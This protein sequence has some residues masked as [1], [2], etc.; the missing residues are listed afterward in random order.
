MLHNSG[1]ALEPHSGIYGRFWQWQ[2]GAVRLTV[3]LHEH[4]VPDFDVAIAI[5]FCRTRRAAP[6]VIAMIKED[7]GAR[8][9]RTGVTHLPE[10]IRSERTAFIIA[11]ADNAFFWNAD[12]FFPDFKR[13]VISLIDSDPQ[14]FFRQIEPVFAGQ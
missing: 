13:F 4:D 2:H 12:F 11:D 10:V 1:D 5:F 9:A 6:D 7:F 3:E 14:L 8:A